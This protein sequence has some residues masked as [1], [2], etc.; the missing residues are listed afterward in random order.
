MRRSYVA[1]RVRAPASVIYALLASSWSLDSSPS[2]PSLAPIKRWGCAKHGKEP[3]L[4][5]PAPG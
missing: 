4:A 1:D 5:S 2:Q 3:G